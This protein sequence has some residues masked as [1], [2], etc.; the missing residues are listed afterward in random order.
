MALAI[1]LAVAAANGKLEARLILS[2]HVTVDAKGN[3][4]S[5]T[6]DN[7][8]KLPGGIDSLFRQTS[9]TW[10]FSPVVVDGVAQNV[11][12]RMKL[13]VVAQK[14]DGNLQVHLDHATFSSEKS[15]SKNAGSKRVPPQYPDVAVRYRTA[16]NTYVAAHVAADGHVTEAFT[17]QVNFKNDV[18]PVNRDLLR[19]AFASASEQ[20]VAQWT[21]DPP[22]SKPTSADGSWTIEVPFDYNLNVNGQSTTP[23]HD[24]WQ[25]YLVGAK[26]SP[27]WL[28]AQN[29]A[30]PQGGLYVIDVGQILNDPPST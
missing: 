11:Q 25:S 8:E 30:L 7:P 2:G 24:G 4:S 3:I 29:D 10:R 15:G 22:A 9:Q 12:A 20:A 26:A 19:K 5:Y 17:E 14:I 13:T 6:F 23:E 27:P 18:D 28:H 21:F 1:P 16:A